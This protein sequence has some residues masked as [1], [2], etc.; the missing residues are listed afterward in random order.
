MIP[1]L[2]LLCSRCRRFCCSAHDPCCWGVLLH[3]TPPAAAG[4]ATT[5]RP[6]HR[7]TRSIQDAPTLGIRAPHV[8]RS[9]HP[10]REFFVQCAGIHV[11]VCFIFR[12]P[13]IRR[14]SPLRVRKAQLHTPLP[15]KIPAGPTPAFQRCNRHMFPQ[16]RSLKLS[17]L[18]IC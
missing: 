4:W 3:A 17:P 6:E 5:A 10:I 11:Y 9:F 7:R 18:F 14:R 16:F 13:P 2:T 12:T 15:C 1:N 8:L